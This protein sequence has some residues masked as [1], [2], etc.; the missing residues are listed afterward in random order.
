MQHRPGVVNQHLAVDT[1]E[2]NTMT[3]LYKVRASFIKEEHYGLA[4]ARAVDLPPLV[5]EVAE[6][7]TTALD[8]QVEAKRKSSKAVAIAKRRKLVLSLRETLKQAQNSPMDGPVL[9]GWLRKLQEEFV[10]RMEGIDRDVEDGVEEEA[11][12]GEDVVREGPGTGK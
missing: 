10:R 2:A 4:L 12:D 1:S 11:E 7:V 3:I 9:L 6:R 8:E 5:L